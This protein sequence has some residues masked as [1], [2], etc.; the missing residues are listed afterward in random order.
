[1]TRMLLAIF[2]VLA[3]TASINTSSV[4]QADTL[5]FAFK[6]QDASA[7]F[8]STDPSGCVQTYVSISAR[9]GSAKT[10]DP[11]PVA[12][13]AATISIEKSDMCT[14][15]PSG[16][17]L[18]SVFGEPALTAD[19]FQ[20]NDLTSATLR[21]KFELFDFASET[22]FTVSLNLSWSGVG[23][24]FD[25]KNHDHIT[26]PNLKIDSHGK[27]TIR[28]ATASGTVTN[29][30]TNFTPSTTDSA[31]L[32]SIKAGTVFVIHE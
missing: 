19:Q 24:T 13:S 18:L 17:P 11:K 21:G 30:T 6:G 26:M 29:G 5:H 25:V 31:A 20:I 28:T 12:Q 8:I 15:P 27:G 22:Q 1:M 4:A 9:D 2:V 32:G 3:T 14:P 23:D 16:R 10:G 7:V